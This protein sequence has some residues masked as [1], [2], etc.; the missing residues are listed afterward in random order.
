MKISIAGLVAFLL[1]FAAGCGGGGSGDSPKPLPDPDNDPSVPTAHL[2]SATAGVGGR[3]APSSQRVGDRAVAV[4]TVTPEL[5]YVIGSVQGCGGSLSTTL[6]TTAPVTAGCTIIAEFAANPY[7]IQLSPPVVEYAL[8]PG[9]EA[10]LRPGLRYAGDGFLHFELVESPSGMTVNDRTGTLRWTP[11]DDQAGQVFTVQMSATDGDTSSSLAFSVR[12]AQPTVVSTHSDVLADGRT[13]VTVTDP[14]LA[15]DGLA[16]V[17]P[18]DFIASDYVTS[19]RGGLPGIA[20]IDPR[21][22]PS[23]DR[24]PS[25]I[26]T[27]VTEFFRIDPVA[28]QTDFIAVRFP[29]PELPEGRHPEEL[30]LYVYAQPDGSLGVGD[31]IWIPVTHALTVTE[32]GQVFVLIATTGHPMVVGLGPA[33]AISGDT[34]SAVFQYSLATAVAG[35]ATVPIQC[36]SDALRIDRQLCT[37]EFPQTGGAQSRCSLDGLTDCMARVRIRDFSENA[38]SAKPVDFSVHHVA[39]WAAD[40]LIKFDTFKL[41]FDAWSRF[42]WLT[43]ISDALVKANIEVQVEDME[44]TRGGYVAGVDGHR[45]LHVNSYSECQNPLAAEMM[46]SVVVHEYFHHAQSRAGY[47]FGEDA[48]LWLSEGTAVW[49]QD[50]VYDDHNFYLGFGIPRILARGLTSSTQ[51]LQTLGFGQSLPA[52]P[53][54]VYPGYDRASFFKLLQR[55]NTATGQD[56]YGCDFEAVNSSQRTFL[57]EIFRGHSVG[58]D[59]GSRLIDVVGDQSFAC[60]FGSTF[61]SLNTMANALEYYTY[62][63]EIQAN[64]RLL[65]HN[66]PGGNPTPWRYAADVQTDAEAPTTWMMH[67]DPLSS[68]VI[69]LRD[70][71]GI[72]APRRLA[73]AISPLSEGMQAFASFRN[74]TGEYE[75]HAIVSGEITD[76]SGGGTWD[77]WFLTL[78]NPDPTRRAVV[79]FFVVREG[80]SS[81]IAIEPIAGQNCTR[82]GVCGW[83]LVVGS[84]IVLSQLSI[85]IDW[86]DGN[87]LGAVTVQDCL[88]SGYCRDMGDGRI[89]FWKAYS[90]PAAYSASIGFSF[91]DGTWESSQ[92]VFLVSEVGLLTL[93]AVPGDGSAMLTWED[94]GADRYNLCQANEPVVVFDNCSVY[95]GGT[96]SLNVSTPFEYGGLTNGTTYH[97]RAEALFGR[98]RLISTGAAAT[99]G[100]LSITFPLNDTGM[101]WCADPNN[102]DLGC[103]VD[104]YP[105]QDGD[106]GRDAR[107]R[108]GVLTKIGGGAAGFDFTKL[109]GSGDELSATAASW[110]CVRD[111]HTGLIWE[112]KSLD[113]GLHDKSNT[114]TW[115]NPDSATNGGNSGTLDGGNCSGSRCDTD[116]FVDAV[117]S[118]ALCGFT[119]WRLPTHHELLSIVHAGRRHPAIDV[120]YFPNTPFLVYAY[121]RAWTAT[122]TWD[123]VLAIDF[124][125]G[126]SDSMSRGSRLYIRLVRKTGKPI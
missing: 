27:R 3:V 112:A 59:G 82:F 17:L 11:T 30:I 34:S 58:Q 21:E 102:N 5:G 19:V 56:R 9:S 118:R 72:P 65:D 44:C 101:D 90:D 111:N 113:G 63:T 80:S 53:P 92:V 84:E 104:G 67:L 98:E 39:G 124:S 117:N 22:A 86:G 25:E 18:E 71:S 1:L 114:Y 122:P 28:I 4:V 2:V 12:V 33:P 46:K 93:D 38:W 115:F 70:P 20:L 24:F 57:G 94:L 126:Q 31:P 75:Q 125:R 15:L 110:A 89:R 123:G 16:V 81:P 88:A 116:G 109:D 42:H 40:A 41:P 68:R 8:L 51:P 106:W 96:L 66:E 60:D 91:G 37:V 119:D 35:T 121:Q 74:D 13:K 45:V 76:L 49:F 78:V 10:E 55:S 79:E 43:P 83:D 23:P 85:E 69:R 97:F 100:A 54:T 29:S 103:P 77:G 36:E 50:E 52:P 73:L 61:S 48:R 120:D 26:A 108:A 64:L 62:A 95:T 14:S 7:P 32:D 87:L 107:A 105:N 6:F 99:L 47:R